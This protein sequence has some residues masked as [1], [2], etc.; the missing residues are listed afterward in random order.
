M[1]EAASEWGSEPVSQWVGELAI[2]EATIGEA[3]TG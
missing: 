3:V 2:S 1:G